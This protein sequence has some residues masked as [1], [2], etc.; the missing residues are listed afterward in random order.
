[1]DIKI[2]SLI[3]QPYVENAIIHGI[4]HLEERRGLIRIEYSYSGH[5][6][7]IVI[8]DNGKGRAFS[9]TLDKTKANSYGMAISQSR[10]EHFNYLQ[11]GSICLIDLTD[12][13]GQP[14]GTQVEVML[15]VT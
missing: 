1:M 11:K 15:P 13:N 4:R 12:E 2:P 7:I 3:V 9:N 5:N 10:I 8:R 6:L 14:S